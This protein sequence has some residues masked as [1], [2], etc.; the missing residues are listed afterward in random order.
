MGT[1]GRGRRSLD[2]LKPQGALLPLALAAGAGLLFLGRKQVG[3][4][5]SAFISEISDL[6][7][8]PRALIQYAPLLITAGQR[9]GVPSSLLAGI[10][11][12]ES[13]AGVALTP[14]GPSGT[15]DWTPRKPTS[16]YFR[17][18]DPSTGL[19]IDGLGWGRGLMQIDYGVHNAW[20]TSHDWGDAETNI[21]KAASILADFFAYFRRSPGNVV[22]I[23]SWRLPAW[24][25]KRPGLAAGPYTDPRPLS[26]IAL[27]EAAL[28]AY[29]A[30]ASGVLQAMAAGLPAST[31]TTGGE[32]ASWILS[33]VASWG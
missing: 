31:P 15:G 9:Y 18:A 33:R 21:N 8:L 16:L 5:V 22:T 10:M 19:P 13:N 30:G 4:A 6:A 2:G 11:W 1:K 27:T 20:V 12:R 23:D 32:Y 25:A 26:G 14:P 3:S 24:Q 29:N 7:Q 17:Y 28:A